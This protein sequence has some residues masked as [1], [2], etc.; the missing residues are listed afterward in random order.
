METLQKLIRL[1]E[2]KTGLTYEA[3]PLNAETCFATS[4]EELRDEF[5]LTFS[6]CDLK[7]Y[8]N[9]LENKPF[10]DPSSSEVFWKIVN[11]QKRLDSKF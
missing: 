3:E 8:L 4:N 1:I 10:V 5:K 2:I 7:N 11:E 9:F 6:P